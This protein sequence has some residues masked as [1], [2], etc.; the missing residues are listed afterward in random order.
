MILC[1][2]RLY[3]HNAPN[4]FAQSMFNVIQATFSQYIYGR[5]AIKGHVVTQ[6]TRSLQCFSVSNRETQWC[7]LHYCCFLSSYSRSHPCASSLSP[8]L[9]PPLFFH[10]FLFTFVG[11][12]CWCWCCAR[13]CVMGSLL[14]WA[15][16]TNSPQQSTWAAVHP[17]RPAFSSA[18]TRAMGHVC[19]SI[20]SLKLSRSYGLSFGFQFCKQSNLIGWSVVN[21]RLCDC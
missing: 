4:T 13:Y 6:M 18:G 12:S 5:K 9:A 15:P 21:L 7:G 1:F 16:C 2:C 8:A 20:T 3:Y 19:E 14:G 11:R 17:D 10:D